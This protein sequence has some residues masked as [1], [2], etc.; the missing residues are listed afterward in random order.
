[1]FSGQYIALSLAKRG[2]WAREAAVSNLSLAQRAD[3]TWTI[4]TR[5]KIA[6][7][8]RDLIVSCYYSFKIG[9]RLSKEYLREKHED[10]DIFR[11]SSHHNQSH[12]IF[13]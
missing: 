1:M 4:A 10:L 12:L 9:Y 7:L 6:L 2:R 3:H 5:F 8:S 13:A 11:Y